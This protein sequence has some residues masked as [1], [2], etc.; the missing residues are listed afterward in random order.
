M[1]KVINIDTAL[2]LSKKLKNK[3][4][5]IVLVGGVFDLLHKGHI[6]FLKAA[7]KQGDVL[8]VMLESD[9]KIKT[10]KGLDR[11]FDSQSRRASILSSLPEVTFVVNL[12]FFTNDQAYDNLVLALKPDIIAITKGDPNKIHK[13]RQA[14]KLHAKVVEVIERIPDLSTTALAKKIKK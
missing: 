3:H 13:I 14:K 1:K 11:P 7:K 4:K 9:E 6:E 2:D 10:L 12:P 5:T 8:F